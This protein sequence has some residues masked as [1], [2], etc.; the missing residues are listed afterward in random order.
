M[1]P[2]TIA[3]RWRLARGR[4]RRRLHCYETEFRGAVA[5]AFMV[6]ARRP[7]SSQ[8][9][10]QIRSAFCTH[11]NPV[12]FLSRPSSFQSA[13]SALACASSPGDG[14]TFRR[15]LGLSNDTFDLHRAR[16]GVEGGF[17]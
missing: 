9:Y 5:M 1:L 8:Q 6:S 16:L 14:A 3:G 4:A 15:R 7:P 10:V 11:A 17:E 2:N 13:R 12:V